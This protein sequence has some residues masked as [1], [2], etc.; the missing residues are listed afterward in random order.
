MDWKQG[1]IGVVTDTRRRLGDGPVNEEYHPQTE[2]RFPGSLKEKL[3]FM[4]RHGN[5]VRMHGHEQPF[6]N[7]AWRQ[8]FLTSD[9]HRNRLVEEIRANFIDDSSEPNRQKSRVAT[10]LKSEKGRENTPQIASEDNKPKD[11]VRD[12]SAHDKISLETAS[13]QDEKNIEKG[14]TEEAIKKVIQI[15]PKFPK[16]EKN[17][18]T[19]QGKG[20]TIESSVEPEE[21]EGISQEAIIKVRRI[22]PNFP[23]CEEN[24]STEQGK[25]P[26]RDSVENAIRSIKGMEIYVSADPDEEKPNEENGDRANEKKMKEEEREKFIKLGVV[27]ALVAFG[28]YHLGYNIGSSEKTCK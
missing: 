27:L 25:I 13:T 23:K 20:Y 28:A 17:E 9:R 4:S 11:H 18:S 1:A 10:S 7:N 14:T 21:Q 24:K 22:Q 6:L 19:E 12:V 3:R 15:Q 16:D 5:N 8:Y 2:N 26:S